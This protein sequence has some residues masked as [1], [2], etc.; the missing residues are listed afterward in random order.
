VTEAAAAWTTLPEHPLL[1][2]GP[3]QIIFENRARDVY[4]DLP[5]LASSIQAKGVIQPLAVQATDDPNRF[6]LL[7]GGRRYSAAVMA[8]LRP[9]PVIVFPID[10]SDLDKEEIELFENIHRKALLW[11]EESKLIRSIQK[12]MEEKH[13]IAVGGTEGEKTG[14]SQADTAALLG[15]ER[16]TVSKAIKRADALD[17][18]PELA[19]AKTASDAD[20]LLKKIQ[21]QGEAEKAVRKYEEENDHAGDEEN[22]KRALA[23]GYLIGDFFE[24]VKNIPDAAANLI[25]ID[26][27]YG[28]DLEDIKRTHASNTE[29]YTEADAATY[30]TFVDAVIEQCVRVLHPGGWMICWHAH[31]W[32]YEVRGSM[33]KHGLEV[34]PIPA[35]WTKPIQGQTNAPQTR[36]GSVVEPFLY[37]RKG[38]GIIVKQGRNNRFE[39]A[40]VSS[41]KKIHPTERPIEM[42]QEVLQTFAQA[43]SRVFVPFLGSGNTLLAANNAGMPAFGFDLDKEGEYQPNFTKRVQDGKLRQYR[44]Y[45]VV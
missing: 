7:A 9:L 27:P 18:H 30:P 19:R 40:P 2:V 8:R 24:G 34:C 38:S 6:R 26:P 11:P 4:E 41:E 20:K 32:Q 15:K 31:Q 13:G 37:G 33:L 17:Q 16:S 28:I 36:L 14:H 25:E 5:E 35:F 3:E 12:L 10:L 22:G 21:R 42:I 45:D 43:N 29:G 1:H 23:K 39:Y 44:S